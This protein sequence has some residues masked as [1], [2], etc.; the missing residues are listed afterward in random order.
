MPP[1][2]S[3]AQS[4]PEPFGVQIDLK[5]KEILRVAFSATPQIRFEPTRPYSEDDLLG[6]DGRFILGN[7]EHSFGI[8]LTVASDVGNRLGRKRVRATERSNPF[9]KRGL[10]PITVIPIDKGLAERIKN[11]TLNQIYLA[12]RATI[13]AAQ[14]IFQIFLKELQC[15]DQY[16]YQTIMRQ[17]NR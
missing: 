8:D 4:S 1:S 9:T 17:L 3:E 10:P 13:Q 7:E 16:S 2:P 5:A 12:D 11:L 14:A 6:I 15:I